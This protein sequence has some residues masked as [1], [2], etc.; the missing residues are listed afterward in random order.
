M[1]RMQKQNLYNIKRYFEKKTGTRLLPRYSENEN[2][3][4]TQ[5]KVFRPA[6]MIAVLSTLCL[7]LVAFTWPL[8]SPLDGDAL[9]LSAT[10]EGNGIVRIQVENRSHKE[11][12]FQP[13]TKLYHWIT[14]EEVQQVSDDISFEGTSISPKST[15]TMTV[16]LSSAYNMKLLEESM[17]KDWYYLLLTNNNFIF[18]QEW[19]CSVFFGKEPEH[20]ESPD[21]PFY[22]LDP[23]ILDQVE[24]ELRFYF[25]DD[26]IGSFAGNPLNYEYL[27]KTEEYLLRCGKKI[28]KSVNPGLMAKTIPDGIIFDETV[29]PEKQYALAGQTSSLHDAF[30]KFVGSGEYESFQVLDVFLPAYEGSDDQAWALP[31]VYLATFEKSAIDTGEECAFIHGQIVS[32]NDLARYLVYED[33]YFVCYNVTDLFY[34][35]LRDYVENVVAMNDA[36]NYKYHY[37]DEQVYTRIQNVY[38]YY[39]DN[40]SIVSR[41]EFLGLRPDCVIEDYPVSS[42]L[43]KE[44]LSGTITS[45]YD[46]EKIV[47][48]I[49]TQADG[50]EVH[51]ATIVP[52]DLHYYDL[53]NATEVSTLIKGLDEGVYVIDVAVWINS[54][55]MGY[56]SLMSMMFTTG[57]AQI[58]AP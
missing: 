9:T 37:F 43:V 40:L 14:G 7:L 10:Y 33:E 48:S 17:E 4:A 39:K 31:L 28:I 20:I 47:I 23:V 18:G 6:V 53:S 35:D 2:Q 42:V 44:G 27:Q 50:A 3:P 1:N 12:E 55:I 19:K 13:Q 58:P 32:F 36:G 34:T 22:T 5:R 30:G 51:T 26:Y 8:F 15:E 16:N 52:E 21:A 45:E 11:L 38:N 49:T 57:N 41:D 24:E 56:R 46:I 25:E 29:A 54:E